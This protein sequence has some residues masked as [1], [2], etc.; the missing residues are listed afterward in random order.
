[1]S[2]GGRVQLA[3]VGA[4]DIYLTANPQMSYFLKTY[5]RH[6]KFAMQTIEVPFESVLPYLD[7]LIELLFL[8][9]EI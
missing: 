8:E 1:M 9:L 4:Q 7:R 2:S 5:S 6:S 3:A